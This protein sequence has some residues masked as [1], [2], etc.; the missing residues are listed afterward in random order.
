MGTQAEFE[1]WPNRGP[2]V[3]RV[4]VAMTIFAALS[5]A[6]RLALRFRVSPWMGLSDW[7]MLAGTVG[8]Q[9]VDVAAFREHK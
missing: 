3:I 1:E 5:T 2:E 4:A 8:C 6:W 7:L 9:S